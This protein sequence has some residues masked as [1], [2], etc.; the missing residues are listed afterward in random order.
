MITL[1]N[2]LDD[3]NDKI[4]YADKIIEHANPVELPSIAASVN[5][6]GLSTDDIGYKLAIALYC[7][8][9]END[10]DYVDAYDLIVQNAN[11][12]EFGLKDR[13][14]RLTG[15]VISEGTIIYKSI[16]GIREKK[17]EF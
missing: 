12:K 17:Y 5:S 8:D 1:L 13:I 4:Q 7:V 14:G 10:Y 6:L 9:R 2:Q 11:L 3:N 15:K 16:T